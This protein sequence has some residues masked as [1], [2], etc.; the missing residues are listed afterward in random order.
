MPMG[1]SVLLTPKK[2]GATSNTHCA[3]NACYGMDYNVDCPNSWSACLMPKAVQHN[4]LSLEMQSSASRFHFMWNSLNEGPW[5]G[6]RPLTNVPRLPS[7]V[8]QNCFIKI[9][10]TDTCSQG[11][12]HDLQTNPNASSAVLSEVI[13]CLCRYRRRSSSRRSSDADAVCQWCSTAGS[14]RP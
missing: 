1:L 9:H 3:D 6:G 12:M 10:W 14:H 7:S 11:L 2:C 13:V 8:T 4:L 5:S